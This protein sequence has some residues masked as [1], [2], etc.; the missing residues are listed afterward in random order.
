MCSRARREKLSVKHLGIR[1]P[2]DFTE[3]RTRLMRA[4]LARTTTSPGQSMQPGSPF[5][6]DLPLWGEQDYF[7][8]LHL[9][10]EAPPGP[11][12]RKPWVVYWTPWMVSA[13][14]EACPWD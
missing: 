11:L 1:P 10:C 7:P 8:L 5:Y 12:N 4:V 13:K 9:A 3:P 6:G 14:L 2:S